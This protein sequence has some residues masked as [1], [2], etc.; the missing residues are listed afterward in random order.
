MTKW[1]ISLSKVIQHFLTLIHQWVV[2][3]KNFT[4][5]FGLVVYSIEQCIFKQERDLLFPKICFESQW[6]NGT[7]NSPRSAQILTNTGNIS[8]HVLYLIWKKTLNFDFR[9]TQLG[10]GYLPSLFWDQTWKIYLIRG[11]YAELHRMQPGEMQTVSY[12]RAKTN[13]F[14]KQTKI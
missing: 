7:Q 4:L 12:F 1:L 9:Y 14:Q 10:H 3:F 5:A 8:W 2:V 6:Y 13:L 11:V